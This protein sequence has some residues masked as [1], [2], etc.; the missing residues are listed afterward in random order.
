MVTQSSASSVWLVKV[1][2]HS[3]LTTWSGALLFLYEMWVITRKSSI[4][5]CDNT[6]EAKLDEDMLT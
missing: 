3:P 2:R 6:T 1:V 5:G 4:D